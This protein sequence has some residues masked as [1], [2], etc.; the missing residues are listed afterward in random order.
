MNSYT[1][2]PT[3]KHA[4]IIL[5]CYGC[6]KEQCNYEPIKTVYEIQQNAVIPQ[7]EKK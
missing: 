2:C 1:N 5:G 4:V 6:Y 3:C 7:E